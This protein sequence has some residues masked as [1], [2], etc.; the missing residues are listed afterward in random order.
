LNGKRLLGR[1]E[2]TKKRVNN[3]SKILGGGNEKLK[4]EKNEKIVKGKHGFDVSERGR[5]SVS[6]KSGWK[7][8]SSSSAI[9]GFFL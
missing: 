1:T 5:S 8:D 2:L 9:F 3:A 4:G 6:V 7:R